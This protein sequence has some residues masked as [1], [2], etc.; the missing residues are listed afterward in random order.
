MKKIAIALALSAA[1]CCPAQNL[2]RNGDFQSVDQDGK[3]TDW[4]YNTKAYS[5]VQSDRPGETGKKV[6]MVKLA[7]PEEKPDAKVSADLRQRIQLK[8]G[9]Y[10]ISLT[11]KVIGQGV[12]S[13]FWGFLDQNRKMM[14]MKAPWWSKSCLK[15][16]WQTVTGIIDVPEGTKFVDIV[17]TSYVYGKYKHKAGTM[18]IAGVD[19]APAD[20]AAEKK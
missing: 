18:Y 7:L 10:Q 2:I 3:L 11:G 20:A 17:V 16:S 6:V 9:K 19:L 8:P 4:K 12:V 13:C 15:P 14:K 1:I 5:Q